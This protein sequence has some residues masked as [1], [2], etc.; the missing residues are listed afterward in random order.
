MSI[1]VKRCRAMSIT[2]NQ[3]QPMSV[4]ASQCQP[5]SINVKQRHS[6]PV[7]PTSASQ[8]FR[9]RVALIH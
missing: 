3:C 1:D 7:L 9:R 6:T 2:V 4:N 8:S 5:V